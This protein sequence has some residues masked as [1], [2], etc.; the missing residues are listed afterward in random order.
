MK[1]KI[2]FIWPRKHNILGVDVSATTYDKALHIVIRAAKERRSVCVSHLAVHGLVQASQDTH[3]RSML[4]DFEIIAP[5][6]MPVKMALNLLYRA[7]LP[8]RVC[9]PDFMLH[10]C[11][12]A[13]IEKIGIYLYGS[14]PHVVKALQDNL[15]TRYPG[16][17]IVGSEPSVFRPLKEEEND[18]LVRRINESGAG[19][20]FIGLGCPLQERFAYENRAKIKTVQICVGAA[21]DFHSGEKMRAPEWMRLNSLEWLYRLLQEPQ[22][23]FRRYFRTNT[24]FLSKFFLQLIRL[25]KF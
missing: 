14:H 7:Q 9:G 19:I 11:K 20:V 13:A 24:I 22:R 17:R 6:G 23:L 21:F 10:V 2:S 12:R 18:A 3:L 5:D 1:D 15:I 8:D 4:N 25:K 16:L